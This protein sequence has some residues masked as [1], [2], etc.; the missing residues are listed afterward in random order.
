MHKVFIVVIAWMSEVGNVMFRMLQRN[1]M[2]AQGIHCCYGL[3]LGIWVH[4]GLYGSEELNM[5]TRYSLLLLLGSQ[6]LGT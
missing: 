1:R 2:C 6:K 4:T 3:N 5:C